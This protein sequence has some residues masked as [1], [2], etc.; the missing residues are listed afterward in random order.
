MAQFLIVDVHRCTGCRNC[1]LACSVRNR[2]TF[3]P[4]LARIRVVRDEARGLVVPVV[5][6]QCEEPLCRDACPVGAIVEGVSGVLTV[7]QD[8]CIGCG[9]CVTACVYGGIVLEPVSRRAIKCDLCGGDPACVEACEY[10]A[11]TVGDSASTD[12]ADRARGMS[13]VL[14]EYGLVTEVRE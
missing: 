4:A 9:N 13:P 1:E 10:G 2:N 14:R 5:C 11:L 3:S 7:N 6:L 8:L 12:R